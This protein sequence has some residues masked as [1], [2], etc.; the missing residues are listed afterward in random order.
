LLVIILILSVG[1][2][3]DFKIKIDIYDYYQILLKIQFSKFIVVDA[4]YIKSYES[5]PSKDI[6]TI[7]N[8][9][10]NS[11]NSATNFSKPEYYAQFP[12][13]TV[14]LTNGAN[15]NLSSGGAGTNFGITDIFG[16][17]AFQPPFDIIFKPSNSEYEYLEELNANG[18]TLQNSKEENKKV[19]QNIGT[20]L[21]LPAGTVLYKKCKSENFKLATGVYHIKGY[22]L[23]TIVESN[24]NS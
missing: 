16:E 4:K 15:D 22:D 11:S 14:V 23:R 7:N 2:V 21:I 20:N 17:L 18:I 3:A 19:M 9:K 10:Y 5:S 6:I 8:I 12:E 24:K 1:Q 13:K